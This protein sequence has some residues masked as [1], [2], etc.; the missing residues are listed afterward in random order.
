MEIISFTRVFRLDRP[1]KKYLDQSLK[2]LSKDDKIVANQIACNHGNRMF[3]HNI[4]NFGTF[5]NVLCSSNA[6][7]N[8]WKNHSTSASS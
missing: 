3:Q 1:E 5:S 4:K 6:P 2:F 8:L 7:V